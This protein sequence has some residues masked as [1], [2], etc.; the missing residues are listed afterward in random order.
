MS[1]AE[2]LKILA[3]YSTK[4]QPSQ[5]TIEISDTKTN[6]TTNN[7][8][9]SPIC[10]FMGHVD[11]GKTSLMDVIRNSNVADYEAG[12]ITQSIGSSFVDIEKLKK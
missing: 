11:A 7:K 9:K 12:K 1:E 10:C 2:R 3:R 5:K 8:L 4:S 6:N